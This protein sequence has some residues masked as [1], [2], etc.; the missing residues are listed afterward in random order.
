MTQVCVVTLKLA[1][2]KVIS[3]KSRSLCTHSHNPCLSHNS[4]LW[5]WILIIFHTIIVHGPRVC[6]DLGS[7]T[8][9]RSRSE[10]TL[11]HNLCLCG[12]SLSPCWIWIKWYTI[13]DH[14]PRM[15]RMCHGLESRSYLQG[16]GPSAYI[17]KIHVQAISPYC[18]IGSC[19]LDDS[20]HNC[21]P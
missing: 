4:S 8:S 16:Q 19:H 5:C 2:M 13:N 20:I 6:H 1:W 21:C 15:W 18:H 14:D 3:P 17:P 9:P 12:N 7:V 11:T 10:Y